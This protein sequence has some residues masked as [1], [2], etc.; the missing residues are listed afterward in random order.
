MKQNNLGFGANSGIEIT[1]DPK[2]SLLS[3]QISIG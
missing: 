3:A 1:A 2:C